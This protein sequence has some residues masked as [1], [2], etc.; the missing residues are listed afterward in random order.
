MNR[1]NKCHLCFTNTD[2]C[3]SHVLPAFLFR[4]LRRSS[5]TG[6]IRDARQ[7]DLRIQDGYKVRWL[8]SNCEQLLGTSEKQ[9][10]D[11]LFYPLSNDTLTSTTYG[12]WLMK[13]CVSISWRVIHKC[14][15]DNLF[16]NYPKKD[17]KLIDEAEEV[18]RQF[19]LGNL[20]SITT[21]PQ[22]LLMMNRVQSTVGNVP[23]DFNVYGRRTVLAGINDDEDSLYV[24]AKLP[25]FFIRGVVSDNNPQSWIDTTIYL[26]GGQIRLKQCPSEHFFSFVE[27]HI[28]IGRESTESMSDRQKE[29]ILSDL[30][31]NPNRFAN[32]DTHR[33][34]EK[35]RALRDG[36]SN[37]PPLVDSPSTESNQ[38]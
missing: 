7:I 33:A 12:P 6:H 38:D 1:D 20:S 37:Q 19:L 17:R 3:K 5:G 4:W 30:K 9:F 8:C 14:R 2:L 22:H 34:K 13:F 29:K 18:W 21:F 28:R 35:D 11:S 15:C 10:A 25:F 27:D 24:Y 36:C 26:Q 31:S 23:F 16:V 32:S